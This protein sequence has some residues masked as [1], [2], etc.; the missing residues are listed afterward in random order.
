MQDLKDHVMGFTFHSHQ[1]S[2]NQVSERLC[3]C[4]SPLWLPVGKELKVS[5]NVWG[6]QVNVQEKDGRRERDRPPGERQTREIATDGE[7]ER[8]Y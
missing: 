8:G 1:L 4:L 3:C 6:D 7:I 5:K 2:G